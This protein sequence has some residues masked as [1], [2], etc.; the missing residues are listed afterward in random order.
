MVLK[1]NH[2]TDHYDEHHNMSINVRDRL[3][4][5]EILSDLELKDLVFADEHDFCE[6]NF[7]SVCPLMLFKQTILHYYNE[8]YDINH[9]FK[10]KSLE[11]DLISMMYYT[12]KSLI[13]YENSDFDELE[14]I[15]SDY[16]IKCLEKSIMTTFTF[17][18][19]IPQ[20]VEFINKLEYALAEIK[21]S[22][23]KCKTLPKFYL[24]NDNSSRLA[25]NKLNSKINYRNLLWKSFYKIIGILITIKINRQ[26]ETG[27]LEAFNTMKK[28]IDDLLVISG[29]R[30]G[31]LF[32]PVSI[33]ETKSKTKLKNQIKEL[34]K[35]LVLV[36]AWDLNNASNVIRELTYL[37]NAN[38]N[39][40][41]KEI[42]KNRNNKNSDTLALYAY[43]LY[44]IE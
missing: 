44:N 8:E 41:E 13:T 32:I 11:Y 28:A 12:F 30:V 27:S 40:I 3:L 43:H 5:A 25:S 31:N 6:K 38:I 15:K 39:Q 16:I 36:S 33:G 18:R 17:D 29:E 42:E 7:I 19:S 34:N 22:I 24:A 21:D 1:N 10:I 20:P 35:N 14:N 9:E 2:K 26:V 37:K 23:Y 4:D